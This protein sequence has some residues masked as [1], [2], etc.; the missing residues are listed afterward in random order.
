MCVCVCVR[1]KKIGYYSV[2]CVVDISSFKSVNV[3]GDAKTK[4][5]A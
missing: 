2:R 4:I 5:F 1:E 3:F